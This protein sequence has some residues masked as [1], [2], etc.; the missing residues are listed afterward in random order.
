MQ[1]KFDRPVTLTQVQV[2]DAAG[3]E[4]GQPAQLR[5]FARDLHSLSSARFAA[6]VS[7]TISCTDDTIQ[8]F[9]TEVHRG[10]APPLLVSGGFPHR[11]QELDLERTSDQP[12]A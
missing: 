6:L 7:S 11:D 2:T 4:S 3:G 10:D 9:R 12:L 5:I 8:A 1:V